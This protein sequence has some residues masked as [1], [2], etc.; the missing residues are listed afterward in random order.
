MVVAMVLGWG[1]APAGAQQSSHETSP[2]LA[3]PL[4]RVLTAGMLGQVSDLN[5]E[6]RGEDCDE[7]AGSLGDFF[8]SVTFN[9]YI[10]TSY[11]WNA[12]QPREV[13]VENVGRIFQQQHNEFQLNAV[14]LLVEK[15]VDEDNLVGFTVDVLLGQ[16]APLIQSAGL[17]GSGNLDLVQANV[18]LL[19]PWSGGTHIVAGKFLTTAGAE[20]IYAPDNDNV[21]RSFIFGLAIPFTH[22]GVSARQPLLQREDGEN[23]LDV[24]VGVANGWDQ[25]ANNNN[26][27]LGMFSSNLDLFDGL[28]ITNNFFWS[29]S[30][31]AA[32]NSNSRVL[33]D[34]VASVYPYQLMGSENEGAQDLKFLF[35][36]DVGGEE[37]AGQR[38]G[39]RGDY[40][41]WW[42]FAGIV[43]H[44][45]S[46][47][48]DENRRNVYL[49]LRGETFNDKD[50][51]RTGGFNVA[52]AQANALRMY[53]LT[54]TLG[55]EPWEVL[56]LRTEVRHDHASE[57]VFAHSAGSR[58]NNQTTV[59]ID[60]IFKI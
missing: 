60:A 57:K 31:Q 34:L 25:V 26:G 58:R 44:D 29:A 9:G 45:F 7:D 14:E 40:A 41:T 18:Q 49:A 4:S 50:L 8:K 54:L 59:A 30:E 2:S 16:T 35:N 32:N 43:R 17:A 10:E 20:V 47:G 23:L 46:M 6:G 19:S 56:L 55:W 22:T 1:A 27:V 52:G 12:Q 24:Y 13:P 21:T 48:A 42:G 37:G 53:E 33:Y 38:A 15:S 39:K 3:G 5:E 28:S 11:T 51:A 36:L